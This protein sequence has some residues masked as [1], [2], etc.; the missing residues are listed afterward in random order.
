MWF[1]GTEVFTA[2][3]TMF[4]FCHQPSMFWQSGTCSIYCLSLWYF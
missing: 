1:V 3:S 4:V 2:A